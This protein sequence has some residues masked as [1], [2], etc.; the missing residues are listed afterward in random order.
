MLNTQD[1]LAVKESDV[2]VF[3]EAADATASVEAQDNSALLKA[4]SERPANALAEAAWQ[5]ALALYAPVYPYST[6]L[7][8]LRANYRGQV[9]SLLEAAGWVEQPVGT[10]RCNVD[11][12]RDG[13]PECI[14]ASE[15]FYA[16]FEI[17][18][19][20]L[21]YLFQRQADGIKTAHQIIGPT[22]QLISGLS[23][24]QSWDLRGGL[25]AD[26]AVIPGAFAENGTSYQATL[27]GGQL[28]F[29]S[30]DHTSQ[31]IYMLQREGLRATF[32]TALPKNLQIPLLLD[33][34]MRFAPGWS[35]QYQREELPSGW[36]VS[37]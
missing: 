6:D 28:T 35:A 23:D 14:L 16:Q 12:D 17:E 5:A 31:K 32:R 24:P 34:W 9:W 20:G 19:G 27:S 18:S 21:T 10:N 2:T 26:P 37:S 29:T 3:G 36:K 8:A 11:P 22:S 1:L 33:S 13:Q 7:P 30:A 25:S 15:Q 4:L